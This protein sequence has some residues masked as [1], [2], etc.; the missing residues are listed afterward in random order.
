MAYE[1]LYPEYGGN[2]IYNLSQTILE[3]YGV[4]SRRTMDDINLKKRN[5]IIILDAFG[6]NI[7][8]KIAKEVKH[9]KITSVFPT[10]TCTVMTTITTGM[11]PGEHGIIGFLG[12]DERYGKTVNLLEFFNQEKIDDNSLQWIFSKI[13]NFYIDANVGVIIPFYTINV[14]LVYVL[15]KPY[16]SY[17]YVDI[18]DALNLVDILF[19]KNKDLIIFYVPHI[20]IISHFYGPNSSITL[21]SARDIFEKIF[22]FSLKRRDEIGIIITADHGQ[23]EAEGV[24]DFD[25]EIFSKNKMPVLGDVRMHIFNEKIDLRFDNYKVL[26][27]SEAEM[28]LGK[29]PEKYK[30]SYFGISLDKKFYMTPLIEKQTRFYKGQHSSILKEEMEIPLIN[31]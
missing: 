10:T 22:N 18:S 19:E 21:N 6:Y 17:Y 26:S 27:E 30:S 16:E 12:Y 31:L 23:I 13:W 15:T 3:N 20:D 25:D 11:L 7:F 14:P 1:I 4:K 24:Y 29:I 8:E 5:L 2:S 28:L 9:R